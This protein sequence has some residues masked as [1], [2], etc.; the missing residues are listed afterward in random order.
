MAKLI[1]LAT[2]SVTNG[3]LQTGRT[4]HST[5]SNERRIGIFDYNFVENCQYGLYILY[6]V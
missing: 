3:K 6:M 1:E 4:A 2:A 5:L